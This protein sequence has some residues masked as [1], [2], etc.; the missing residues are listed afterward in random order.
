MAAQTHTAGDQAHSQVHPTPALNLS[1]CV[2]LSYTLPGQMKNGR[3]FPFG[4]HQFQGP[5]HI[6]T[7]IR[8]VLV[9]FTAHCS[10]VY[11]C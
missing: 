7:E 3:V 8:G 6:P 5:V 2:V 1:T 9:G 10:D 11:R 4:E